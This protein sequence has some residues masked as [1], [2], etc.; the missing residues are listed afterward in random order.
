MT[1]PWLALTL[2]LIPMAALAADPGAGVAQAAARAGGLEGRILWCD[3][4]ANLPILATRAGIASVM[5]RASRARFN[6]VVLDVKPISGHV[7][8]QSRLAPRL[9]EWRGQTVP[10]DH[11][12]LAVAVEEAHARGLA[13]YASLNIFAEGHRHFGVGPGYSRPGWQS[14][15][16]VSD[17]EVAAP[18]G[19]RTG[20]AG[21]DPAATGPGLWAFTK[22]SR[23]LADD[24]SAAVVE[25][26][27]VAGLVGHA[28]AGAAPLPVPAGGLLLAGRGGGRDWLE[29]QL[30]PGQTLSFHARHR[31]VRAAD[32][33]D[34]AALMVQPAN[35]EVRAYEQVLLE[36]VAR[37]YGV[38]G[39]VLDRMRYGSL[40]MDFSP[41]SRQQFE[42]WL[43]QPVAR[44]P[45]DILTPHPRP[46]GGVQPGRF[47]R[48]WLQWRAETIRSFLAESVSRVK[49]VRPDLKVGVYVGSW[50]P[51]YYTVG[52]NWAADDYAPGY[53]WMSPGYPATGY[54]GLVDFVT[55]GCYYALPWR[56][57]ALRQGE[58]EAGTV[59]AAASG[60]NRAV[61]DASFVYAGLYLAHYSRPEQ[62]EE[63]MRAARSQTQ[64]VMLFDLSYLTGD[65]WWEMLERAFRDVARPPH[66]VAGLLDH[67]RAARRADSLARQPGP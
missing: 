55:T 40:W 51:T 34:G 18:T 59:E 6:I 64:G 16:L 62:L 61:S 35:P 28:F 26:D 42:R 20:L 17:R 15:A 19:A 67:I 5:E 39:L 3:A 57:D 13:L 65:G 9:A 48:E 11:D 25:G 23:R 27:R 4:T 29:K 47:Y 58:P 1:R 56:A 46:G 44:F 41:M 45:E 30:A 50:Y 22:G 54:A 2:W 49:A 24:E 43:G 53:D 12:I 37:G 21:A 31:I 7:L 66:S 60:S 14:E 33:E 63:A 32:G 52:A 36:E 8:F 10:P 38:D